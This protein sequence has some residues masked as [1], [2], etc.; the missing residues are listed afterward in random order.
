LDSTIYCSNVCVLR[1]PS[2]L[3]ICAMNACRRLCDD[4]I[5]VLRIFAAG[6][7]SNIWNPWD[8]F[9]STQAETESDSDRCPRPLE[10]A[11]LV[12]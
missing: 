5:V 3:V 10:S 11:G 12:F 8:V 4:F 9:R 1:T 7:L 2:S 6:W